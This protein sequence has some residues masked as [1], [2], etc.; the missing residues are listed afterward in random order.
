MVVLGESVG[1]VANLLQEPQCKGIAS[2]SQGF[3][4]ARQIDFLFAFR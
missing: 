2:E 3:L 1:F 4:F